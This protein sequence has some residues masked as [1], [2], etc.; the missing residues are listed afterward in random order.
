MEDTYQKYRFSAISIKKEVAVRFREF[1]RLVSDSHTRTLEAIMDFFEWNDLSPNDD[2][3]IKNNRTNK[4]INAV[5]A[6][7]KNIEKY[8][9]L[10]TKTMLDTL[11]HEISQVEGMEEEEENHDFGTPES[12]TRDTELEHYRNRHE[13]MLLQ[14]SHY[15]NQ[16]QELLERLTYIKSAF[17]KGHYKLDMDKNDLENFKKSL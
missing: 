14:L 9:T 8:Q 13:E 16:M 10:P 17:G 2:L 11:F 3:G 7:L 5:I 1:S 12:F 4:R 15:K 6:I